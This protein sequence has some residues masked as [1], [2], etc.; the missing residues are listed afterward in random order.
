MRNNKFAKHAA[1]RLARKLESGDI[2]TV[3][4][5]FTHPDNIASNGD[6]N[7]QSCLRLVK[8]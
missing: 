7:C 6:V 3:C 8:K 5:R 1:P 2:E 4:G